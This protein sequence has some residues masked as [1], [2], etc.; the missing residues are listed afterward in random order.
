MQGEILS[1]KFF[2]FAW[3][4]HRQKRLKG[5]A[6]VSGRNRD[7]QWIGIGPG[8][9]VGLGLRVGV[10]HYGAYLAGPIFIVDPRQIFLFRQIYYFTMLAGLRPKELSIT[11]D[12][13]HAPAD[14]WRRS[15]YGP[16]WGV[17]GGIVNVLRRLATLVVQ[18]DPSRPERKS[19][20]SNNLWRSSIMHKLCSTDPMSTFV[21]WINA[22]A[23][24]DQ[25]KHHS[26]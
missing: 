5:V 14:S 4:A 19:V 18:S 9:V 25:L 13:G 15:T 12:A 16:I 1:F 17:L 2:A 3:P 6:W 24:I 22:T 20:L 10:N 21:N 7:L 11:T 8:S 23:T 26:N